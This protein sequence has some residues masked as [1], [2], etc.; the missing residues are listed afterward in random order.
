[1]ILPN[2]SNAWYNAKLKGA[3]DLSGETD[4][5]RK[6]AVFFSWNFYEYI[7]ELKDICQ[8]FATQN[9]MYC[10]FKKS[11]VVPLCLRN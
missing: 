4:C 5:L 8:E 11:Y 10:N 3:N 6:I 7:C 1:M 9:D 2:E